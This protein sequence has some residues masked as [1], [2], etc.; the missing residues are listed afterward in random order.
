MRRSFVAL[1]LL[2]ACAAPPTPP[3]ATVPAS[4][5]NGLTLV[6]APAKTIAEPRIRVGM[7]SDQPSVSFPRINGGYY[8]ISDTATATLKRG[9]TDTAPVSNA[10]IRY[11]VQVSALSDEASANAFAD[12]VRAETGQRVDVV[13]D[14]SGGLRR[15]IAGDFPTSAAAQP[16]R[17]QLTSYGP[18]LMIVRRPSDQPFTRQ[19]QIVDDEGEQYTIAGESI[20]IM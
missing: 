15:I 9:F 4:S 3:P 16:L 12:R 18:N 1:F 2:A 14:P 10:V 6:A 19:H 13:F 17:D 20:L 11:G 5:P 7:L 8:L